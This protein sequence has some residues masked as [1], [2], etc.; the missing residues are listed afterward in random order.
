MSIIKIGVLGLQGAVEEHVCKL[1]SLKD[2]QPVVVKKQEQLEEIQGL[3]IPGGES[4]AMGK[5]LDDFNLINTVNERI[6]NGMAVWGTCAGMIILA[7][8]ITNQDKTFLKVMD[9]EVKRNAYGSQMD[10]FITWRV[11]KDVSPEPIPLVF[12]RAPYIESCGDEVQILCKIQDKIV[13]CREGKIL[14][15]AFH[16]ELSENLSFHKY[17]VEKVVYGL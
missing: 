8:K 9:I 7:K 1:N 6:N 17:F 15:T 11:I 10:S 2:I 13:A 5:L 12:I 3:I 16:P 4:T 14:A